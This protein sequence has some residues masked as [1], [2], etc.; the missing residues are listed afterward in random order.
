MP[1]NIDRLDE[2]ARSVVNVNLIFKNEI[3]VSTCL[4]RFPWRQTLPLNKRMQVFFV[5]SWAI[6]EQLVCAR[7]VR[8]A[9]QWFE[10]LHQQSSNQL[11]S[12]PLGHCLEGSGLESRICVIQR[13]W[14]CLLG[15]QILPKVFPIQLGHQSSRGGLT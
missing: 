6:L 9:G 3:A 13:T 4:N 5:D 10:C 2:A 1:F 15:C 11:P 14:P 12:D 7:E 8:A